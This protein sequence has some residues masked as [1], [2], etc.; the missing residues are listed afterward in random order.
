MFRKTITGLVAAAAMAAP[1]ALAAPAQAAPAADKT[2]LDV[3]NSVDRFTSTEKKGLDRFRWDQ[4]NWYDFDILTAAVVANETFVPA[5]TDSKTAVTLFAP[6]DRAF[7]LLA[8]D[9]TGKWY[10][11]ESAVLKAIVGA[12]GTGDALTKV[13]SYHL[14]GSKVVKA[15]VPL[16]TPVATLNGGET[17]KFTAKW[18]GIMVKDNAK[19]FRNPTLVRTD[20]DAGKSVIHS[21]SRV[22]VPSNL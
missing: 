10:W 20:I 19:D 7:Q 16:N 1:L 4:R 8:K 15:D 12:V 3:V 17:I 21:L 9:L 13:L 6:N 11:T 18:Y 2:I 22:L 5:V 14:L